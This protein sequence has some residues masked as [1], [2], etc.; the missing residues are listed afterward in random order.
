MREAREDFGAGCSGHV[1]VDCDRD[2]SVCGTGLSVELRGSGAINTV[3]ASG[4]PSFAGSTLS[5]K[6]RKSW[7]QRVSSG[8]SRVEAG[9]G[10][11]GLV[12]ETAVSC[13]PEPLLVVI[14]ENSPRFG[15]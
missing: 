11:N 2:S 13:E 15:R 4:N 8:Q 5:L 3:A 10:G 9:S 7:D 6:K 1:L 14:V 12:G